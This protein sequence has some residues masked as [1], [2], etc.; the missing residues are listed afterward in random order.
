MDSHCTAWGYL[1]WRK[2]HWGL[3]CEVVLKQ[4]SEEI[5]LPKT[6]IIFVWKEIRD[7]MSRMVLWGASFSLVKQP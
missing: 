7:K 4:F 5:Q 1:C 2:T 6:I 3:N